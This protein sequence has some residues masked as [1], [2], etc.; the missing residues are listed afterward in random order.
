MLW[1]NQ[2]SNENFTFA[3]INNFLFHAKK[4]HLQDISTFLVANKTL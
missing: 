2:V 1:E 3:P 4:S